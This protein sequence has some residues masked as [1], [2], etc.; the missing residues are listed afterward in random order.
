MRPVT[1]KIRLVKHKAEHNF[2]EGTATTPR[3]QSYPSLDEYSEGD[4]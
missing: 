2:L 4:F 1:I 3:P